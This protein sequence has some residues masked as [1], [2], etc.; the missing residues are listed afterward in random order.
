MESFS[1][2]DKDSEIVLK[3][4][5]D[6][7]NNFEDLLDLSYRDF[8]NNKFTNS[9][10]NSI[11]HKLL[12]EGYIHPFYESRTAT[13]YLNVQITHEGYS[14]FKILRKELFYFWIPIIV[15]NAIAFVALIISIIALLK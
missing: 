3:R 11:C 13:D 9:F 7:T 15:S 12:R 1:R 10:I 6:K 4:I 5:I 8:D 2:M 14:Y